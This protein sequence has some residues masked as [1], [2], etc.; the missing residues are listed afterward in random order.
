MVLA[1]TYDD[2]KYSPHPFP[3]AV[4]VA[5][6]DDTKWDMYATEHSYL[7]VWWPQS[8]KG[9]MAIYPKELVGHNL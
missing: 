5:I 9:E 3:G 8:D 2:I 7:T 1:H 6:A 4:V